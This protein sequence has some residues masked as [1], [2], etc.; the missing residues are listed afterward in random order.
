MNGERKA[1]TGADEQQGS[2]AG[3]LRAEVR[4]WL[5][6]NW[7]PDMAL[8]DWRRLLIDEGW[9]V[10]SYP[11]EWLGRGLPRWADAVVAEEIEAAGAVG[12]PLGVGAGLA[13]PTILA[14]GSDDLRT[15][16]LR[17]I[18]TG[19]QTWC[20][21]F[22][23]PGAG[24]DLAGLV[25][26]AHLDGDEWVVSGQK[27]WNTSA[28]HADFGLLLARTDTSVPKHQG[29][30]YFVLPMRQPGVEV[31][32]LRQMNGHSSFNEVFLSE[33]RIP[34]DHVVGE[35]GGGW[36]VASTTLQYERRFGAM[37]QHDFAGR[38]GKAID[39]ARR[40]AKRHAETYKWYP[41]RAGRVDL[42]LELARSLGQ[43]QDP[44][45]RQ[46]IAKLLSLHRASAWT[47]ERARIAL[48]RGARPSAEGSLG[49]LANSQIARQAAS[50]HSLIAGTHSMLTGPESLMGGVIAEVLVST[51]AQSIAGGTDQIQRNIVG[52]KMLGLP[53]EPSVETGRAFRD[54]RRSG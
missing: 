8:I 42:V 20:Q 54:V 25:T 49:K 51:P 22:S 4:S 37:R 45:L 30:T 12:N 39:E 35:V 34:V 43:D 21:L 32:P 50:V 5:A 44:I 7:D 40:E 15:R 19:E 28:D 2:D 52:E 6:Q 3:A 16:F 23:E 10:P 31:R 1:G 36:S 26:G 18:L 33:A 29:L 27:V 38:S 46:E 41:Q 14:H 13:A 48:K 11:R 47:A 9:G 53:K 17:P 24:S